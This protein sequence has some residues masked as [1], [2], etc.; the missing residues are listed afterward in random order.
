VRGEGGNT[1][2]LVGR[3]ELNLPVDPAG[4]EESRVQDVDT[5]C[6]HDDLEG[7]GEGRSIQ[8]DSQ[9]WAVK[10]MKSFLSQGSTL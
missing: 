5:V 9:Q 2:R 3:R 8:R 6:G 10:A 7:W 4:S 1:H